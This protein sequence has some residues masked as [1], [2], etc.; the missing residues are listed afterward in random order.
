MRSL[1]LCRVLAAGILLGGCSASSPRYSAGNT[2]T[3]YL[4]GIASYYAEES[5]G[6]KTASGEVY[7]MEALT[8]AHPTLP[9]DT[10]VR[11]T[12]LENGKSVVVRINDRGPH[13][14]GRILD[15]SY[16]AARIIGMIP[17]GTARV[18]VEV[19]SLGRVGS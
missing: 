11:V 1:G 10:Q 6:L 18:R 5:H 16:R 19:L 4:E 14:K 7:D 15:L 8:A 13:K 3:D 2:G 17:E 9:Y 12:N